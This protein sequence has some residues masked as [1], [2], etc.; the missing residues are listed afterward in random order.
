MF[1]GL[2]LYFTFNEMYLLIMIYWG[3]KRL[4]G[5]KNTVQGTISLC[6]TLGLHA[7]LNAI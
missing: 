4:A 3:K 2:N 5:R 1:S 6:S 7:A